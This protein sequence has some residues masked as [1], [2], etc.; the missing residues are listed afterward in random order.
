MSHNEHLA[1]FLK[2]PGKVTK[3]GKRMSPACKPWLVNS[4]NHHLKMFPTAIPEAQLF[5]TKKAF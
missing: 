3:T 2:I 1:L 4:K 5:P